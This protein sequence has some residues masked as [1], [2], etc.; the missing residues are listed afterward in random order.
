MKQI[1]YIAAASILVWLTGCA[2][3][4]KIVVQDR[5]GP[6]HQVPSE[7]VSDG[8]LQV[9]SARES[10]LLDVNAETFFCNNDYG[11][12]DYLYGTAHT[13]YTL[14]TADG[15]V[16]EHVRN[17]RSHNSAGPTLLKLPAGSYTIEAEAEKFPGVNMTVV[18]PVAIKPGQ[19]TTVHLEPNWSPIGEAMDPARLVRLADGRVLGCREQ[20]LLGRVAR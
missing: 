11:K 13:D 4:S 1:N 17:A 5:L 9:Y 7:S 14:F 16:L 10:A 8:A 12:N 2:S 6:C 3:A 15:T 20:I 19:T 18:I